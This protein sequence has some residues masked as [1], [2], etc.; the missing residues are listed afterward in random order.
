[1]NKKTK[2]HQEGMGVRVVHPDEKTTVA[3]IIAGAVFDT[4]SS[5]TVPLAETKSRT[6]K[7]RAPKRSK[8]AQEEEMARQQR[9][10]RLAGEI[11]RVAGQS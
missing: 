11:A 9:G 4:S 7:V 8:T 10:V 1:M 6:T 2:A 3:P 5:E